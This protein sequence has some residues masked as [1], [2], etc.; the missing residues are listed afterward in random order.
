MNRMIKRLLA[1]VLITS[2][3]LGSNGISYA[4]EIADGDSIAGTEEVAQAAEV[5]EQEESPEDA[6]A[7]EPAEE[8]SAAEEQAQEEE[9]EGQEAE[10]QT[11]EETDAEASEED[12]AAEENSEAASAEEVDDATEQEDAGAEDAAAAEDADVAVTEETTAAENADTATAVE[13]TA[14]EVAAAQAQEEVFTAGELVYHG[15]DYDVTLA[16]DENAKI[17]ATAELKVREI[18]KGTSEYES[19]LA[20]AEAAAGKGVAE[21]RFFDI[22]I[23][24]AGTDG[25]QQE[26]Q[27]QSQVRVNI[28]YHKALE[29]AAEGEVQAMHFEDGTADAEVVGTDTNGGSEVSEIAFDAASFSVY[30]IVYTVD[31]TYG[32]YTYSMPGEGSIYLSELAK[33]LGLYERDID[34]E[35]CVGNVS[36]VTLNN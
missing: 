15:H 28:T 23:V 1:A 13:P 24:A 29:V 27:P 4:A 17:P 9:G 30:G 21:A 31:F 14:E 5:E 36:N 6:E 34:K 33:I 7:S 8:E 26:I 2:M 19:Y 16:Y 10:A 35:F 22:T 20:G 3:L 25:Q 12:N 18:A 32:G 11:V